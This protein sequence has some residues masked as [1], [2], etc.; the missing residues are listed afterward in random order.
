MSYTDIRAM[1]MRYRSWYIDR[2]IK[3]L[4]EEQKAYNNASNAAKPKKNKF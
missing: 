3:S 2:F 1:P 4:K